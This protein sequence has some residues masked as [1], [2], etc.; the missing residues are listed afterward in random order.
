LSNELEITGSASL[1]V[2]GVL[3]QPSIPPGSANEK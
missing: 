2:N 1:A 3:T